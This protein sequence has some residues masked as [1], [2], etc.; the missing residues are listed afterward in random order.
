MSTVIHTDT[1]IDEFSVIHRNLYRMKID[2]D[3]R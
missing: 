1:T 3:Q 2:P